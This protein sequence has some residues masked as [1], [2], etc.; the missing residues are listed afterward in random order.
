MAIALVVWWIGAQA[1]AFTGPNKGF[2]ATGH[3]SKARFIMDNW[4]RVSWNYEWYS[5][6]PAFSD[7][8]LYHVLLALIATVGRVSL[9]TAMNAVACASMFLSVAGLYATV[10]AATG[11]RVAG[12]TA[13]ALVVGL[14]RSGSRSWSLASIRG[15]PGSA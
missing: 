8:P 7:Y 11:S 5:G 12:M 10:R 13:A 1:H 14:R 2:D 6:E 4:P 3:L 9:P 15:S